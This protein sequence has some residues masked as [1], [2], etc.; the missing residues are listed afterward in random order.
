MATTSL[1]FP[2]L[3]SIL[4]GQIIVTR[5]ITP[6]AAVLLC[7]PED[8]VELAPGDLTFTCNGSVTFPDCLPLTN[9]MRKVKLGGGWAWAMV[10]LD[11]RWRWASGSISGEY[12]RRLPNGSIDPDTQMTPGELADLCLEEMGE[13]GYDTSEMPSSVYPYVN[14]NNLV[15]ALALKQVCEAVACEVCGGEIASVFIQPLGTGQDLPAGGNP[16]H[17]PATMTRP[18]QPTRIVLYGGNNVYCSQLKLAAVGPESDGTTKRINDLSYKP[19]GGW[20]SELPGVFGGL[21]TSNQIL[22]QGGVWRWYDVIGQSDGSLAV[23]G[24]NT[25]VSSIDQYVFLDTRLDQD[26][27]LSS[28]KRPL[29]PKVTGTFWDYAD[30]PTDTAANTYYSGP[31]QWDVAR[32][33]V[34]FPL[35]I[36]SFS[37]AQQPQEPTLNFIA[38]YHVKDFDG[39][40]ERLVRVRQIG[41]AGGDFIIRRPELFDTVNQ[42][43]AAGVGSAE[44][45]ETLDLW[46]QAFNEDVLADVSYAGLIDVLPSGIIAQVTITGS[47]IGDEGWTTRVCR[48]EEMNPEAPSEKERKRRELLALLAEELGQ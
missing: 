31:F 27:D 42:G 3:A 10:I 46:E 5:G 30:L 34:I 4:R 47:S 9:T 8:G 23:P 19:S 17:P 29:S 43:T 1:T 36:F 22:A 33:R 15:P 28:V 44:A 12:N 32:G 25:A 6:S 18:N 24:S 40:P 11:H 35:P 13:T 39:N 38:S 2:G 41:G 37:S 14:W 21:S 7:V 20:G 26:T 48:L 45:E 16:L